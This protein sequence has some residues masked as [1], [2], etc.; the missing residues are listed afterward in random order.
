MVAWTQDDLSR[1]PEEPPTRKTRRNRCNR[2]PLVSSKATT[3]TQSP[4]LSPDCI[5][6]GKHCLVQHKF[7]QIQFRFR[8]WFHWIREA[9]MMPTSI[10]TNIMWSSDNELQLLVIGT[11]FILT[12]YIADVGV[13]GVYVAQMKMLFFSW[14]MNP[15]FSLHRPR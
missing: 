7:M 6:V 14:R 10:R 2:Y 4:S 8:S 9:V 5:S 13:A 1:R 3:L 11:L 12:I 15:I